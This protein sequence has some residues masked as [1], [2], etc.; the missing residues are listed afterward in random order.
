MDLENLIINGI[1]IRTSE[2]LDQIRLIQNPISNKYIEMHV[3]INDKWEIFIIP[4]TE[5]QHIISFLTQCEHNFILC[6]A[7]GSTG[8]DISRP[9]ITKCIKCGYIV[10][11]S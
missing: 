5:K 2:L 11:Q 3:L 8:N 6:Y 9:Q 10:N 4:K 7:D 1:S